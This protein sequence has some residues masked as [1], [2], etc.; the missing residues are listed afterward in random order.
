[1]NLFKFNNF[2]VLLDY[3]HNV[4]GFLELEKY[5]AKTEATEKIGVLGVTGDRRDE[6]LMEIG[7]ISGRMFD[8]IIFKHDRDLRGRTQSEMEE[9]FM[10]GLREVNADMIVEMIAV[11]EKAISKALSGVQ[12]NSF[13]VICADDISACIA[14][15]RHAQKKENQADEQSPHVGKK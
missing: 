8:R 7:R 4:D 11:E 5:V 12:K 10:K 3:A 1:M 6:D 2:E 9:L 14:Q 13:V 15:L